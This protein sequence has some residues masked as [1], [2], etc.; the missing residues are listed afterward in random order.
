MVD[1]DFAQSEPRNTTAEDLTSK[2]DQTIVIA[3]ISEGF[4]AGFKR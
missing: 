3:D 4:G 1:L 2:I